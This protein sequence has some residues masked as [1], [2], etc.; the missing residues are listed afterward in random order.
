MTDRLHSYHKKNRRTYKS[1]GLHKAF[2]KGGIP[3]LV[4]NSKSSEI[5][6]CVHK[7]SLLLPE[8]LKM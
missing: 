1:R 2:N 8:Y 6:K 7:I 4:K 5:K 3:L